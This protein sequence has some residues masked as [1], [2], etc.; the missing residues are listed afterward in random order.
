MASFYFRVTILILSLFFFAGYLTISPL[1]HLPIYRLPARFEASKK[2]DEER[3]L[4]RVSRF[5]SLFPKS[6]ITRS[7]DRPSVWISLPHR[8]NRNRN[9]EKSTTRSSCRYRGCIKKMRM[10]RYEPPMKTKDVSWSSN[11]NQ[12][13]FKDIAVQVIEKL[14]CK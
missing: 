3:N 13:L 6:Q 14:Y 4:T 5:A 10:K 2:S 9:N 7:N 1:S 12:N 11:K 8:S